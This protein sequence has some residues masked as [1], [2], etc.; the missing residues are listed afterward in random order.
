MAYNHLGRRA[1]L[2]ESISGTAP[3]SD[4][5][6]FIFD[7]SDVVYRE[8]SG[9]SNDQVQFT[10]LDQPDFETVDNGLLYIYGPTGLVM[11]F[12][13][14]GYSNTSRTMLFDPIL[15]R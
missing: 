11:E 1:S 15:L 7:G 4:V 10:L 3:N 9:Y 2:A 13:R 5:Q 8:F 12:D 14:S 6:S